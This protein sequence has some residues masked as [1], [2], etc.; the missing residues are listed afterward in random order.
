VPKFE[1]KF[2]KKTFAAPGKLQAIA[3]RA[4]P[5]VGLCSKPVQGGASVAEAVIIS[6]LKA[7][8]YT[9]AGAKAVS[10]QDEHGASDYDEFNSTFGQY[11]GQARITSRAVAGG[12]TNAT[13]YLRQLAEILETS[14][15]SFVS[16]AERKLLG[17]IGGSIGVI[18]NVTIGADGEMSLT[19]VGDA[20]NF[21]NGMI[22]QAAS[23]AGSSATV[24]ARAGLGYPF[25]VYV[26]GD[27]NGAH[28]HFANSTANAAAG[29]PAIPTD[30]VNGDFLF[31]NG[32]V[33]T[34]TDLSDKQIR[35]LQAWIPLT[36]ATNEYN[37]VDRS[38]D[39]RLSGFRLSAAR[40]AGMSILDRMQLL[41]TTGR[42]QCGATQ[43]QLFVVGPNTWQQLAQEM[44]SY[45]Q[46]MFSDSTRVGI[47]MMKI[48]TAN[49]DCEVLNSPSCIES[50]I[51]LFTENTLK[52]YNYD[53]FPALDDADGNEILKQEGAAGYFIR[54]HAFN[55][56]TVSGK[57]HFN[58]RCPSGN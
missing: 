43:A 29:T 2:L 47:K 12:K 52:I 13:A 35:S 36:A 4:A 55:C 3:D 39:S 6:G 10:D 11:F 25:E 5:F 37:G 27:A 9:V 40:V 58:G 56:V 46:L 30:W 51:W 16:I 49:G 26:D 42:S 45:G 19:V 38:A 50:D 18:D 7:L 32:D 41:A 33:A 54:F 1:D 23:S 31:R 20:Q 53:G 34:N 28:V 8:S 57:P 14:V 22:V 24:T 17:P 44:Q 21:A 15:G 48:I